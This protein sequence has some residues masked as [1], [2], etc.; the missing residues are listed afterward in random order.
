MRSVGILPILLL[1]SCAAVRLEEFSVSAIN[2]EEKPVACAILKDDEFLLT[3]AGE[4]VRAPAKVKIPFQKEKDGAGYASVK[5]G[6]KAVV[7]DEEGKITH[8]VRDRE[9]SPY[10]EQ[11]RHIYPHDP[12]RQ[13]FILIEDPSFRN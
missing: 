11:S 2:V 12:K 10:V 13:L 6:V 1:V 9:R 3:P 5:L 4:H 7:V 8:G